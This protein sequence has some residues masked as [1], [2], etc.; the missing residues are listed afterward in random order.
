MQVPTAVNDLGASTYFTDVPI[1]D[2]VGL[3]SQDAFKDRYKKKYTTD[4]IR[5]LVNAH[6]AQ[7]VCVYD[8]WFSKKGFVPWGGPPLPSEYILIAKLY[9]P[10][11]YKFASDDT[12]SYYAVPGAEQK[13]RTALEKLQTTLPRWDSLTFAPR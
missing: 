4:N 13:L 3:G 8:K 10:D 5:D 6:H 2:L 7:V 1:L 9:S 12:V 11:P